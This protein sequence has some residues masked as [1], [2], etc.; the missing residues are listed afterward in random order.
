MTSERQIVAN[1]QNALKS[2]GPRTPGGRATRH[3]QGVEPPK[4]AEVSREVGVLEK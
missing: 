3:C 2:T 4:A 1:R